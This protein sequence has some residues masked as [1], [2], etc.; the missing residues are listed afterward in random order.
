MSDFLKKQKEVLLYV[1]FGI[2]TTVVSWVTYALFVHLGF[3]VTISNILSWVLAVAFAFVTNKLWVFSSPN[4][5]FSVLLREAGTFLS[6]RIITGILEIVC[7]PLLIATGFDN[8]M[9]NLVHGM[10]IQFAAL[11]TEGIF[12]KMLVTVVVIILNYF[13]S[14]FLVF[15]KKEK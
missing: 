1:L 3:G 5:R 12:S 11:E 10:G 7:V 8:W 15:V 13:F 9:L 6:A 2:L 4:W 14:K